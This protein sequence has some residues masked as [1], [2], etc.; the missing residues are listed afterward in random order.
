MPTTEISQHRS[1]EAGWTAF[2]RSSTWQSVTLRARLLERKPDLA[3]FLSQP[4]WL[5]SLVQCAEALAAASDGEMLRLL[6]E[7]NQ[8]PI[9]WVDYGEITIEFRTAAASTRMNAAQKDALAGFHQALCGDQDLPQALSRIESHLP[10]RSGQYFLLLQRFEDLFTPLTSQTQA[11]GGS[12]PPRTGKV[13][14]RWKFL[15]T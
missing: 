14:R 8:W 6:A 3:K 12:L 5:A 4:A 2:A 11:V 10:S 1:L 9:P 7:N 13:F 15:T